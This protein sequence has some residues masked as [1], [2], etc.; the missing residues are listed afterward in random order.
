[1]KPFPSDQPELRTSRCAR[2]LIVLM[3][4]TAV[5]ELRHQFATLP[6]TLALLR[7]WREPHA[8]YQLALGND[9]GLLRR[10][11]R[12]LPR[13][14]TVLLL[15]SGRDVRHREYT[16]YHRALYFLTP[17]PVWWLTPAPPD[18]TWESRWW[19][20][21]SLTR[22]TI[23]R[24]AAEKGATHLLAL[25]LAELPPAGRKVADLPGGSIL[26][27]ASDEG[28]P[29][30]SATESESLPSLAPL[31]VAV[32]LLAV[33]LLGDVI[34]AA[35][36]RVGLAV[37]GI[38]RV[39]LAWTL[40][41]GVASIAMLWLS[42]VGATLDRQ[43]AI[44]SLAA[45]VAFA[46]VRWRRGMPQVDDAGLSR[47]WGV[48]SRR[49]RPLSFVAFAVLGACLLFV[50]VTAM[51]RPL[52]VWD[53]WVLWGMRARTLLVEGGISSA[54]Y[55]DASRVL[56]LPTYPLLV[57]LLEAWIYTWLGAADDRLAAA[58]VVPFYAALPAVAYAALTR[59]GARR[60]S[61]LLA[62]AALAAVPAL[63]GLAAGVLADLP[64][65]LFTTVAAIY[66]VEWMERGG[67]GALIVAALAAGFLPWTKQEGVV[68]VAVLS[69]GMLI[70]ARGR[71][72]GWVGA[73]TLC[74]SALLLSGPWYAFVAVHGLSGP[75]FDAVTAERLVGNLGRLPS[76]GWRALTVL[77]IPAGAG[78][79]IAAAVFAAVCRPAGAVGCRSALFPL[80]GFLYV[81]TMAWV[82]VFSAYVPYQQHMAASYLRLVAQVTPLPLLWIASHGTPRR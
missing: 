27:L 71:R 63:V 9:Y 19:I 42:A 23:M 4:L 21:G 13:N 40:G 5:V 18:S 37:N 79:W 73:L 26:T 53:S 75:Q 32:A 56:T 72:E 10:A 46:V 7:L 52:T 64:V 36:T 28:A 62:S 20:S 60:D 81:A 58:A 22:E 6:H 41:A 61:A 43:V 3:L 31:R 78:V 54:I 16:T 51:G 1:V 25:D 70:V 15:T 33:L 49:P 45:L 17:R 77:T 11:D 57:P 68:I 30:A 29:R 74:A 69:L 24:V 59:R 44:I 2:A 82:Y 55:A 12:L 38:E 8:Q 34:L 39:A 50:I 66:L 47:W 67:A 35:V 76:I 65:A 14:A 48:V 80:T